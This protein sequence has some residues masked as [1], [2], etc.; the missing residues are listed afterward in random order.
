[1]D[2]LI[3]EAPSLAAMIIMV[4]AFLRYI[5]KRDVAAKELHQES[6][7]IILENSRILGEVG[8]IVRKT[9]GH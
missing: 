1:M 6:N 9:N 3:Q 2:K 5:G 8:E 4:I 7:T